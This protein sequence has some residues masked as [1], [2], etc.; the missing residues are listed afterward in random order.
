MLGDRSVKMLGLSPSSVCTIQSFCLFVLFLRMSERESG[1][2][3]AGEMVQSG[4]CCSHKHKVLTWDPR[5]PHKKQAIMAR[6]S[7]AGDVEMGIP[8]ARSS[9]TKLLS[10]KFKSPCLKK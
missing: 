9:L 6:A 8:G 3:G 7:N 4:K 1:E 10:S 5:H 2:F